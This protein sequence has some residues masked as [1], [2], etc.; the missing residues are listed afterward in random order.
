MS[1]TLVVITSLLCPVVVRLLLNYFTPGLGSIPGPP[2]AR[3]S[4]LW[5]FLDA[6]Y[7][8]HP[9]TIV[10]L[11]K[12]Y[13]P[14]VRIGPRAVS[15]ADPRAIEPVLGL[16]ANLDKSDSVK[17]MMNPYNGEYLPMLIAAM[18]SKAHARI[19]R[20]IGG[21]YSMTT[22][23]SFEATA[24]QVINK[25]VS[26]L[27]RYPDGE[28]C[29]IDQ[30]M[31]FFSFD[32]ILQATFS[33]DFGFVDSGKDVDGMLAMLDLQ[34]A[35]IGTMGV[36]PWLD[37][38]LLKNP[39][40]LML[41]KTPN[42]LVDFASEQVKAR[43][44]SSNKVSIQK[45]D[46]LS[47][48][49]EAQRQYPDIVSDL[50]LTTYAATNVLAGSDTTSGALT[51]IIY[52]ILKNPGVYAR[53]QT[54][55]DAAA[56]TFPVSYT[57]ASNLPYLG[58]TIKEVLRIFPTTGTELERT[59]KA[60]GLVLPTGHRLPAGAIVGLNAWPL[61]RDSK[62]FGKDADEFRPDRWL[63]QPNEPAEEFDSRLKG[64]Q[65]VILTFGAGPRACLGRHIAFLQLYKLIA[66]LFGL[67]EVGLRSKHP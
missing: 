64:M 7:G 25:L 27:S 63:Q 19:K 57:V 66:T 60:D 3:F 12:Q 35:Y 5:R 34:F 38:L 54:E 56:P 36:M 6:C 33:E 37:K 53:V 20:P 51:A 1:V 65:R 26:K 46:F 41:L 8:Q 22:M 23:L 11:H 24:D 13:G 50:Q 15:V 14:V 39:L 21:A 45:L 16:R 55:I 32:F 59:V 52:H 29:S 2:L 18:D 61:H 4:D 10:S 42:T 48:F 62:V 67:F 49:F 9:Q 28:R 47:R 30:W 58:A 17:P 40:L 43:Q 31:A 44:Q